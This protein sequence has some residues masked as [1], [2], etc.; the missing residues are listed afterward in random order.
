MLLFA[1]R[2]EGSVCR[3]LITASRWHL[4]LHTGGAG[5]CCRPRRGWRVSPGAAAPGPPGLALGLG[6]HSPAACFGHHVAM[7]DLY[8]STSV[9]DPRPRLSSRPCARP[10]D[11][12]ANPTLRW[13]FVVDVTQGAP[14]WRKHPKPS[15]WP[16]A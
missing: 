11:V 7:Q 5:A 14:R 2:A 6:P 3:C 15:T 1:G 8:S 12:L 10:P 9:A 4:G 13:D 16:S